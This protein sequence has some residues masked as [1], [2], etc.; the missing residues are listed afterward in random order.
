[1]IAAFGVSNFIFRLVFFKFLLLVYNIFS[2]YAYLQLI[3]MLFIIFVLPINLLNIRN[4]WLP[5]LRT[6]N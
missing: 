3:N 5:L 6:I 1:V 4:H 2:G